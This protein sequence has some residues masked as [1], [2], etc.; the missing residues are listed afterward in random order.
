VATMDQPVMRPRKRRSRFA[1]FVAQIRVRKPP[2][3]RSGRREREVVPSTRWDN[4][5]LAVDRAVNTFLDTSTKVASVRRIEAKSSGPSVH[6]LVTVDGPWEDA[7]DAIEAGLFPKAQAGE[8][9]TFDYD[10][11]V[12]DG[13]R[14]PG[15]VQVYPA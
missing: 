7:I 12:D 3:V 13:P 6:F 14:E 10:V 5:G 9:P 8:L 1:R 11:R 4:V 15:Y 2:E